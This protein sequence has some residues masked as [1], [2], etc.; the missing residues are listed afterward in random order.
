MP[1]EYYDGKLVYDAVVTVG[2]QWTA[3]H[4]SLSRRLCAS[5]S[6]L[7]VLVHLR[8]RV[9]AISETM[10]YQVGLRTDGQYAT[11]NFA[12]HGYGTHQMLA[13]IENGMV[14]SRVKE[15]VR[16]VIYQAIYPEHLYRLAGLR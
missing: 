8:A 16:Y 9:S 10:P 13:A 5:D 2:G 6:I 1:E 4:S 12:V 14:A 15:D 11:Y 3:N 7:R